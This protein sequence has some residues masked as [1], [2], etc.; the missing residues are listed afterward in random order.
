M[1]NISTQQ[2]L[3]NNRNILIVDLLS[4]FSLAWYPMIIIDIGNILADILSYSD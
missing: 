2:K 3:E 1:L 4:Y